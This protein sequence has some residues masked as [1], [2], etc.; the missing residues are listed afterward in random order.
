MTDASTDRA[1][2]LP[3]SQPPAT[4][5]HWRKLTATDIGY[6]L[7]LLDEGKP[8]LEVAQRLHVHPSTICRLVKDLGHDTSDIAKR[9][10]KSSAITAARRSVAIAR[11]GKDEHALKAARLVLEGAGVIDSPQ[12]V[13]NTRVTVVVGLPQQ[14]AWDASAITIEGAKVVEP[15]DPAAPLSLETHENTEQSR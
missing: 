12:A 2:T 15:G 9:Y 1:Q 4:I 10:L 5:G 14:P 11:K 13:G 3:D 8:Q 6:A 7:K